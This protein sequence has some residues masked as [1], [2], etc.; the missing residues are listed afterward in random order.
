MFILIF[1]VIVVGGSLALFAWR[2]PKVGLGGRFDVLSRE[3]MLLANNVLFTVAAGTVLIGTL[4]PLVVDAMAAL[5]VIDQTNKI[6]VGAPYFNSMFIPIMAAVVFLMGVGPVAKWKK[7]TV[8][9]LGRRVRWAAAVAIVMAIITP[10]VMG[11]WSWLVSLGALMAFWVVATVV[12]S[13]RDRL[14]RTPAIS[15]GPCVWWVCPPVTSACNW[16]ISGWRCSSS[17]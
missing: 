9:E 15:P 7:A 6:S 1:L 2:A 11:H 4:A 12:M 10:F 17:A 13:L 14:S 3:T 5:G 16:P 8:P